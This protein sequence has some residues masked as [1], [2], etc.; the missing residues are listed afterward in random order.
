MTALA[1]FDSGVTI[2]TMVI[3]IRIPFIP[4]MGTFN[5]VD[6]IKIGTIFR[7][8]FLDLTAKF[9][10]VKSILAGLAP[11]SMSCPP[12]GFFQFC[13]VNCAIYA[14]VMLVTMAE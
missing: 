6:I 3:A 5:V 14:S 13:P 7:L 2:S 11:P 1:F 12:W 9:A 8:K 4:A 10:L